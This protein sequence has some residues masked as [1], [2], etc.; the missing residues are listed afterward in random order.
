MKLRKLI[1]LL[2]IVLFAGCSRGH[3]D[4][5]NGVARREFPL[6]LLAAFY[7][8]VAWF[9]NN[10]FAIQ[11]FLDVPEHGMPEDFIK[12]YDLTT[13]TL[14]APVAMPKTDATCE[15][16]WATPKWEPAVISRADNGNLII[17][18][19]CSGDPM[20]GPIL[21]LEYDVS[22]GELQKLTDY[23]KQRVGLLHFAFTSENELI[24][25]SPVGHPMNNE[26]Y[27]VSLVDGSVTRILPEF[28]RARWP[29]WSAKNEL[30]AFWGTAQFPGKEP[31][32]LYT[33]DDIETLVRAPWDLY[34]M[35]KDGNNPRIIY[36]L[37]ANIGGL[38][39]SPNGDWLAFGGTVDGVEGI[40]LL[41]I[42]NPEPIRIF[43]HNYVFDWSPDG[44]KIIVVENKE[45]DAQNNDDPVEAFILELP[46]CVF[47]NGCE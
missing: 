29:S 25:E 38:A 6:S 35:D 17:V 19:E 21:L 4:I 42:N 34:V 31:D 24:Q 16:Q 12:I 32:D 20:G 3:A 18:A 26:L 2:I 5:Q 1:G 44:S 47:E 37:I 39:W 14:S 40:W 33:F 45:F 7:R 27:K 22:T 41:D 11:Y 30:V 10:T 9:D 23:N 46:D 28:L 43:D 8:D 13:N 15:S 36:P